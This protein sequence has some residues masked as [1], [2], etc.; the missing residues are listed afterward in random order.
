MAR[1]DAPHQACGVDFTQASQPAFTIPS[2]SRNDRS[3]AARTA[4]R[5]TARATQNGGNVREPCPY[6]EASVRPVDAVVWL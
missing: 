6:R 2:W 4:S 5:P 1:P 3:G